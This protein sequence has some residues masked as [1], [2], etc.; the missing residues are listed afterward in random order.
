M[1]WSGSCWEARDLGSSNG[2]VV[3]GHKLAPGERAALHQ[4]S[5]LRLAN[6]PAW[7][8]IDALPPVA[9]AR[10][11]TGEVRVAEG[12]LLVLPD[13][14]R[15]VACA[16]EDGGGVWWVEVGDETRVA[17]DQETIVAGEPWVLSIPPSVLERPVST[18]LKVERPLDLSNVTLRFAVSSDEEHTTLCILCDDGVKQAGS[19]AY[20]YTLLTLARA[21]LGDREN[22]SG[23]SAEQGW[24]YVEDLLRMLQ[25]DAEKLNV[26]IFRARQHFSQLGILDA[27]AIIQRRPQS[28]QIRI[29]AERIEIV[30]A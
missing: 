19:R 24:I 25:M 4:G 22:A 14:S 2:T 28:R 13:F 17:V 20:I 3:D 29:G 23:P 30:A 18:T 5:E 10:S 26:D 11:A 15:P 6:G 8:L 12:G 7:V 9:A 27:G 16:Y 21:R 1:F